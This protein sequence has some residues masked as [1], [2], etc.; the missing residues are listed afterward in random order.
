[1][2]LS[3]PKMQLYISTSQIKNI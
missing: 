1:M 2:Q 3:V